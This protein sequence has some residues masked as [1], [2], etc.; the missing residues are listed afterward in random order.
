MKIENT[1]LFFLLEYVLHSQ[2]FGLQKLGNLVI[3]KMLL[4]S[5]LHCS[6]NIKINKDPLIVST[7]FTANLLR[8][9]DYF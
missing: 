5:Y 8:E 2:L 4:L 7:T 1:Q 9:Y 3:K 6:K